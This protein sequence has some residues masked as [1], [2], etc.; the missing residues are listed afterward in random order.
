LYVASA[1]RTGHVLP[2]DLNGQRLEGGFDIP[3]GP[4][5]AC[6]VA[7]LFVDDDRRVWLADKNQRVVRGFNLFGRETHRLSSALPSAG[8]GSEPDVEGNLGLPAALAGRGSSDDFLLVV[9]SAGQRRHGAQVL[10]GDGRVLRSLR[11]LGD[12][13]GRFAGVR[14]L[15]LVGRAIVLVEAERP[16]V[17][18]FRDLEHWYCFEP[19]PPRGC[20]AE[21]MSVRSI[22][23]GR[24]MALWGGEQPHLVELDSNGAL[25]RVLVLPGEDVGQLSAPAD[26]V[27]DRE[28]QR[29]AVLDR[30]GDRTQVFT[31]EGQ[32]AGAFACHAS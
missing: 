20:P 12:S 27:L 3:P 30:D 32:C 17:Q 11:P 15:E 28:G 1:E 22:A 19:E 6:R 29:L 10:D 2:F 26:L 25:Q 14:S 23:R 31:L 4:T 24:F 7:G 5:G 21:L 16:R 18:V 13:H 8:T 9:G